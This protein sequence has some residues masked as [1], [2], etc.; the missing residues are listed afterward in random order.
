M[1]NLTLSLMITPLLVACGGGGESGGTSTPAAPIA[2]I[3]AVSQTSDLVAP[4]GFDYNPIESRTLTVDLSASRSQ[5]AYLS[6]YTR[7]VEINGG[8]KVPDYGS[9]VAATQL[10]NGK[11]S[12]DLT[13]ADS[14]DNVLAEV[15]FYDG[16][17]PLQQEFSTN[18]TSWYW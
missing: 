4:E 13:I 5:R 11:A 15:W 18:Q 6:V 2:P 7:Y 1:K 12:I 16:S 9:R 17:D 14:Q 3:A 8:V 10:D